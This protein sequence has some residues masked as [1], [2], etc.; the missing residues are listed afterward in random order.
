MVS[1]LQLGNSLNNALSNILV[2]I[3]GSSSYGVLLSGSSNNTLSNIPITTSGSSAHGAGLS[4]SSNNN[5]INTSM[6][7]S[8]AHGIYLD[9]AATSNNSFTNVTIIRGNATAYDL[10]INT[11][12]INNTNL[13]DTHISRYYFTGV[14]GK[15]IF[16]DTDEGEIRFLTAVNGTGDHLNDDN[17]SAIINI[18]ANYVSVRSDL[19]NGFNK[20][21]NITIYNSDSLGL[22]IKNIYRN[23]VYCPSN[24]CKNLSN[25]DSF[26]FNVT[27]FTDY[28]LKSAGYNACG[29]LNLSNY[30]YTLTSD[31]ES[32]ETC[33]NITAN[34]VTLDCNG[35]KINYSTA[36]ILGYGVYAKNR[37]NVTVKNCNIYEGNSTT[38]F[39]HAIY[40]Y[41]TSNGRIENN[42]FSTIGINA[43]GAILL[44]SSNNIFSAN[45]IWINGNDGVGA[46]LQLSSN[47]SFSANNIWTNGSYA[48]GAY[49]TSSS[50]NSF[51]ANNI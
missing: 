16:K 51:S 28:T 38:I 30:V 37:L 32:T 31:V 27:G 35:Y 6:N 40:Y 26:V 3:N 36:D 11:A 9:T 47:N 14:G 18:S 39:K 17:E 46:Y 33:F 5:F 1:G 23:G 29:M 7:V 45:N 41:N 49:L 13:I 12:G 21:A 19:N 2:V 15:T 4:S 25:A 34:N 48:N 43:Y 10:Y 50:N 24:I 8:L 20:S 42:N 44:S 22:P